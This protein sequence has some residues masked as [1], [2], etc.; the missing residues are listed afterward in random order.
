MHVV[1]WVQA[2]LPLLLCKDKAHYTVLPLACARLVE[3]AK[4]LVLAALLVAGQRTD[5]GLASQE[6]KWI[7]RGIKRQHI[8]G[9]RST[10]KHM[11]WKDKK[12]ADTHADT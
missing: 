10:G 5:K 12:H 9:T 11:E 6:E 8:F 3:A 1:P 2:R 4:Y 7:G